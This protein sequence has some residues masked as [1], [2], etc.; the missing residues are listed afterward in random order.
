MMDQPG[1]EQLMDVDN[2][3][4]LTSSSAEDPRT[5][6]KSNETSSSQTTGLSLRRWTGAGSWKRY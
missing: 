6:K 3:A 4:G 1:K 2:K 5:G